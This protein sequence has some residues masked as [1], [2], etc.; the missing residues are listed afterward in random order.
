MM[1]MLIN[2]EKFALQE[3]VEQVHVSVY[4]WENQVLLFMGREQSNS[5][6]SSLTLIR[7]THDSWFLTA[8]TG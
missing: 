1:I 6:K 4:N 2:D 8:S 3:R 5:V 7:V